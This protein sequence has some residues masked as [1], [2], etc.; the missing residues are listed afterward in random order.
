M[1]QS[2]VIESFLFIIHKHNPLKNQPS[3]K[4]KMPTAQG[5]GHSDLLEI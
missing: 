1:T 4:Q 5:G 3:G 2:L